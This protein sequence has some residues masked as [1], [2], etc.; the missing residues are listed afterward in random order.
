MNHALKVAEGEIVAVFDAD[1]I[2]AED[3]LSKAARYFSDPEVMALQGTVCSI[4]EEENMLTKMIRAMRLAS[5]RL[6]RALFY[7]RNSASSLSN[8]RMPF[9]E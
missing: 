5:G 4:N 8:N 3:V 2:P 9:E 7:W 1:N 6:K